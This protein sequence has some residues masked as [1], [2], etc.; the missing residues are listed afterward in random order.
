MKN[1]MAALF[2]AGILAV[3]TVFGGTPVCAEEDT[4]PVEKDDEVDNAAFTGEGMTTRFLHGSLYDKEIKDE[5]DAQDA[6]EALLEK[7]GGDESTILELAEIRPTEDGVT[8]YTFYQYASGVRV[9]GA[10]VKLIVD[11]GGKAAGLVSAI[12]PKLKNVEPEW[13]I[14]AEEAEAIVEDRFREQ[15]LQAIRGASEQTLLP[16]EEGSDILCYVWIVYTD[17]IYEGSDK[18]YLAHYVMEDGNYMYALPVEEPGNADA[19][20]GDLAPFA[21]DSGEPGT[22]TGELTHRD[23]TKEEVE[24]PV[25]ISQEQNTVILADS[26]RKILCA[27]YVKF[28]KE[29][30]LSMICS[31]DGSWD[32]D[33]LLTYYN[34]IR[35]YDYFKETGWDGPD[36]EETPALLLFGLCDENGDPG[37]NAFY[38]GK[39]RG[40][41]VFE[42]D[43]T[44]Y[45][46]CLD[47]VGHEY[48]HCIT[49]TMMTM[50]LYQN[51]Y[52]A[53][54]EGMSD[55][56]GNLAEYLITGNEEGYWIHGENAKETERSFKDPKSCQQPERVWGEYYVPGV[57]IASDNND[58]GGVHRNSSLLNR[59]S[60]LLYKGGMEPEDQQYF[61]MNVSLAMTPRTDYPQ[62]A[63]MLPWCMETAGYPEFVETV[64][65]AV[66][67]VGIESSEFPDKLEEG[68]GLLTF[69]FPFSDY[70]QGFDI[71]VAC[72]S[73]ERDTEYYTWAGSDDQVRAVLP[74]GKYIVIL[75]F[76]NREEGT[77]YHMMVT[78]EG[79]TEMEKTYAEMT[80]EEVKEAE[81]SVEK[82]IT[83]TVETDTLEELLAA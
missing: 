2:L 59:I 67:E 68:C 27:D 24:L 71:L 66:Q 20:A 34:F 3:G 11:A 62:L 56:F 50:N 8:Y 60:Y 70:S 14:D 31:E 22:W 5:N 4:V 81:I 35:I 1:R 15:K 39:V 32:N 26:E 42:F 77:V 48:T 6:M 63:E 13:T 72:F 76:I 16:L 37:D 19:L 73:N 83:L 29:N 23:G 75:A 33:I 41:H 64:K 45:S 21:F 53:I 38:A 18:A 17:N 65:K 47:V 12:I 7:I 78:D 43:E 44:V 40:F 58:N 69:G 74:E 46:D 51:D 80:D 52:G 79:W 54:N 36:G 28:E 82:G 10:A 25:I 55:I 57:V 61:W 49:S 30:T 9:Y